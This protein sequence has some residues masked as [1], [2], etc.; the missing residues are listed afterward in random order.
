MRY[1]VCLLLGLLFGA[2]LAMT[3]SSA[4]QRRNAWPRAMMI[5]MQHELAGAREAT[6]QG[7]CSDASLASSRAHL[8]LLAD[9]LE[10]ALL[11]KGGKDRVLSQYARDLRES[12]AAWQPDAACAAQVEAVSR[13]S[14]ACDACHR[15]YR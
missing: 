9:D 11:P 6:R 8:A 14:Q 7:R 10:R 2:L 12:V 5:V 13:I 15:D 4:L 3:A 1:L